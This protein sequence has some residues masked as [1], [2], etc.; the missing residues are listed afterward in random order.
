[1]HI[2]DAEYYDEIYGSTTRKRDKYGPWVA[3]AGTPGSSFS[4]VRHDHHKLRRSA[5]SPFFS[6]KA[7]VNLEPVVKTKVDVLSKRFQAAQKT[8]EVIRVDAAFMALTMDIICQYAFANDDNM[9]MKD[10]FNL[11]WKEMIIGAFEGGAMLR[12]L[13]SMFSM[14]NAVP[15]RLMKIMMPSMG[16]MLAWKA[17]VRQRVKPILD[18]T[19]CPSDFEG[20]SHRTIFHELR[21]SSLPV[22]EKC[23]DRLCDEGQILTGAGS[24][25]TA[26]VLTT[27]IFYLLEH[28]DLFM[29]LKEELMSLSTISDTWSKLAQLPY[30]VSTTPS[31]LETKTD[32]ASLL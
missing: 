9:L 6:T 10:D 24:E 13:P 17:G 7:V 27:A 23:L 25:T 28:K 4:T 22:A 29:K 8:G 11:A 32:N 12:Q 30:L 1:M 16:L 19:E 15:D 18:R 5:L 20:V 2:D 26:K 31:C 3:L 14:M 21:D